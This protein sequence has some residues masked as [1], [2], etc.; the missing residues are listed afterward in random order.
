MGVMYLMNDIR[1]QLETRGKGGRR[2]GILSVCSSNPHVI[3][4]AMRRFKAAGFP[5]PLLIESTANQ[6]NQYGGYS[7]MRPSDFKAFVHA[8]ARDES[9]PLEALVLGGDHLGPLTWQHEPAASAM[10]KS[11]ALVDAYVGAGYGKIHLDT[12]MKLGDDPEGPIDTDVVAERSAN[13]AS[14]CEKSFFT[15]QKKHPGA[16]HPI[17]V[18]GSE[19]PQPG[20]T[21]GAEC[22]EVTRPE[23]FERTLASFRKTFNEAGTE[24][25]MKHVVAV[26]VQ[27][28][29]E[30]SNTSICDYVPNAAYDL[31]A[32]LADYP[33]LV[34]EG[35]STD[36]QTREA[37]GQLV[38]GGVGILKVGPGLTF[39]LREGLM[40]LEAMEKQWIIENQHSQFSQVLK[41]TM[42][43][44]PTHWRSY[45]KG[46]KEVERHMQIIFGYSNRCR[47][48]MG[49][50]KVE[51]SVNILL[52]GLSKCPPPL[53]LVSQYMPVQYA[54]I[55]RKQMENTPIALLYDKIG[56]VLDDYLFAVTDACV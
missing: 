39:A 30:F 33:G 55:R 38:Q 54:K 19:V 3:R 42:L 8:L 28:G 27:P 24:A 52:D 2:T 15:F 12:S 13:L 17:Y 29:V 18:I 36:Y 5:L 22:A 20:G 49:H 43:A 7:G 35:H 16:M 50:P 46:D 53:P 31:L 26:V 47:Y 45:C 21:Q 44:D 14:V 48:Y 37:L 9:Y 1:R 56:E 32:C 4:A 41:S 23:D 51:A 6:V 25:V 10:E 34:F 11:C 40:A